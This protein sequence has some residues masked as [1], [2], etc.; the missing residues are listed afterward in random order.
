MNIRKNF[1]TLKRFHNHGL[2]MR[3]NNPLQLGKFVLTVVV[4]LFTIAVFKLIV[5][6]G[7]LKTRDLTSRDHQNCTANRAS[8]SHF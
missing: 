7:R 4:I 1:I 6:L 3:T 5:L 2:S 8:R